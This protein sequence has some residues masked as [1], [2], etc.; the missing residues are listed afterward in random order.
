MLES[1]SQEGSTAGRELLCVG[2]KSICIRIL[3]GQKAPNAERVCTA[4]CRWS[5]GEGAAWAAQGR[6]RGTSSG[7]QLLRCAFIKGPARWPQGR[8]T[9]APGRALPRRAPF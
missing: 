4:I 7:G 5:S 3:Q 1:F 8:A 2:V 9:Y 6:E